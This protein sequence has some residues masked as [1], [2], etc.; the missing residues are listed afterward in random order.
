MEKLRPKYGSEFYFENAFSSLFTQTHSSIKV[1]TDNINEFL[2]Y[3][4][5]LYPEYTLKLTNA[6]NEEEKYKIAS[7]PLNN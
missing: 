1:Y 5:F 6:R 2:Y 4:N 3:Y 7:K